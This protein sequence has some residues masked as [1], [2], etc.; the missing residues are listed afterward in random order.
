MSAFLFLLWFGA[1]A[2]ANG[3]LLKARNI[4]DR[5]VLTRIAGELSLAAQ[6][7][8][9]DAA[10]QYRAAFAQSTLAEVASELRDKDLARSASNAGLGAAERAVKLDPTSAEYH[11][12]RGTLCGQ[13]AAAVGGLGALKFGQCALDEVNKAIDIDPKSS[14][15]YL[16]RGIGNYYLPAALGGGVAIAI[17]DFEKA[18]ALDMK[19]ADAHL[20][21]GLALRKQNQDSAAR[22]EF[23]KALELNP[24]RLWAKQQLQKT[25]EK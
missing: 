16:S 3:D 22:R 5:A 4:Q 21:L 11:R 12:I 10:A 23:Q 8:S 14:L 13:A 19:S 20:W 15:N 25:P 17:Q 7:N 6:K 18:L 9:A 24:A 1:G 2:P